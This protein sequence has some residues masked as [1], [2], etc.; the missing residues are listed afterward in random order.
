MSE[1]DRRRRGGA[2]GA[3]GRR[4]RRRA[5]DDAGRSR[6]PGAGR[7]RGRA[8][9]R[10]SGAGGGRGAGD[11]RRA[12]RRS[13]VSVSSRTSSSASRRR[14]ARSVRET[15]PPAR[16]R[17]PSARR[18]SAARSPSRDWVGIRVPRHRWHRRRPSRVPVA[19]RRLR[20]HPCARAHPALVVCS[21]VKSL[22]DVPATVE[23]LETLGIPVLGFRTDT[24][25]LFYAAEGGPPVPQ[26]VED[27]A[28]AARIARAHWELG[29]AGLVLAQPAARERRRR[30]PDRGGGDR[31]GRRER[32][33]AGGDAV[34]ALVPARATPAAARAR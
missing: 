22:L 25:P 21:G 16:C 33:R 10:S 31:R 8:R 6:V 3:R 24:L 4:C 15:S 26:R 20:R 30:E 14:R 7:G 5:R 12:R 34:R 17:A 29:G 23:L 9:E 32:L 27:A 28:E 1:L 19:S 18:R 11:D 2:R 13:S